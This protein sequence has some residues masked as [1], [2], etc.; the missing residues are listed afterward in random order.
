[1]DCRPRVRQGLFSP[2][3]P[4]PDKWI[5]RPLVWTGVPAAYRTEN[6]WAIGLRRVWARLMGY[7]EAIGR[8]EVIMEAAMTAATWMIVPGDRNVVPR[9]S[10]RLPRCRPTEA[11]L[12]PAGVL[13]FI[14]AV[15]AAG[16]LHSFMILRHGKVAAEGWWRPYGARYP[17][18]LFS[19]SKSFTATAVG[20]A[21]SQGNLT[22]DAPVISFFPDQTPSNPSPNLAA[23]RVR[24]L[25]TMTT[26]HAE[27]TIGR[28]TRAGEQDWVR[29]FLSLPVEH[30]PGSRFIYNSGATY[31]LSAIIQKVTGDRLIEY[32]KPRLFAPLGITSMTWETCPKGINTGGWGLSVRTE[33]VARFGQLYLQRGVW[34]GRRVVPEEWVAQATAKQVSNGSDPN[35][36]WA[37]GYGFQFWRCRHNAYRGDGAFGQFCIVMPDQDAVIAI[38]SG[39]SDMQAILNAVWTHLLP[40]MRDETFATAADEAR[41]RSRIARLEVPCPDGRPS[42]PEARA[43]SGKVYRCD[44]NDAGI[45]TVSLAFSAGRGTLSI[46]DGKGLH[47]VEFGIGGWL[48]GKTTLDAQPSALIAASGAWEDDTTCVVKVCYYETPFVRTFRLRADGDEMTVA[49]RVNVSFGPTEMPTLRA[50]HRPGRTG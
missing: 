37:Q 8:R 32:L 12:D 50:T 9:S 36:D 20:L 47:Q 41:L 44:A 23:M 25:L 35:S 19:L 16:G 6:G 18:M 45:E 22:L 4:H 1:M 31:M 39:V 48:R 33:D 42:S 10:R 7:R 11:G 14:E 5:A 3:V 29:V 49:S 26:G 15:E 40:A 46:R 21:I 30:Q 43:L 13:G 38:T 17:H 24:H 28:T 2:S 34:Q 27:D